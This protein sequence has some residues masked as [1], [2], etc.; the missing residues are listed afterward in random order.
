MAARAGMV[1]LIAELRS[2]TDTA[3]AETTVNGTAYWTDDQLQDILDEIGSDV[4]DDRLIPA[5]LYYNGVYEYRRYYLRQG[6]PLWFEGAA[7]SGA[8]EV[9]D[10][11]GVAPAF[12]Y[13]FNSKRRLIE[14][15]ENTLGKDYFLR[16]RA[17]NLYAAAA[18]VW[19]QKAS[20]RTALV[21]FKAGNN[22]IYEDQEWQHCM[23]MHSFY[24]RKTGFR[25]V[26]MRRVDYGQEYR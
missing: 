4:V 18:E 9:V 12:V 23:K 6:L 10:S 22:Q 25:A 14:F 11:L 3:S 21:D 8:F 26:P 17:F 19:L 16:A 1:A 24:K 7:T 15:A 2:M 13:T 20:H 5:P